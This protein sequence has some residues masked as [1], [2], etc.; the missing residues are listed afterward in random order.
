HRFSRTYIEIETFDG[1]HTAVALAE[2]L[3]ADHRVPF[4]VYSVRAAA[5]AAAGTSSS[6]KPAV[7]GRPCDSVAGS[8]GTPG[9]A[10]VSGNG[11]ST[12][13]RSNTGNACSA[14]DSACAAGVRANASSTGRFAARAPNGS[15]A[16]YGRSPMPS[17]SR[18]NV[19]RA[20]Q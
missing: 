5:T 13:G 3:V 2:I 9:G 4:L 11:S 6:I 15:L 14:H 16:R 17:P 1:G 18:S 19:A 8:S 7:A 10:A 12:C 20:P